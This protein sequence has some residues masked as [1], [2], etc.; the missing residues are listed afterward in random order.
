M[1]EYFTY[2]KLYFVPSQT[3]HVSLDCP[4]SHPHLTFHHHPHQPKLYVLTFK[5]EML[6]SSV[7]VSSCFPGFPN[8]TVSDTSLTLG[9]QLLRHLDCVSQRW[10]FPPL[11]SSSPRRKDPQLWFLLSGPT[12]CCSSHLW[13]Y[14]LEILLAQAQGTLWGMSCL[15]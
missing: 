12:H 6:F 9:L 5:L 14:G 4:L 8:L 2:R 7:R 11:I 10:L 1:V 15:S 13:F 3:E